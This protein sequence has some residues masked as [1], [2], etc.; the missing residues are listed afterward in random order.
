MVDDVLRFG[1]RE[2]GIEQRR[3]AAPGKLFTAG[4]TAQQPDAVTAADLADD[5]IALTSVTKLLVLRVHT[6]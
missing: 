3:P 2:L 4:A 5:E 6:G 1:F